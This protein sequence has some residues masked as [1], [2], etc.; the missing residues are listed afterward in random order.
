MDA[1]MMALEPEKKEPVAVAVVAWKTKAVSWS[2]E[3]KHAGREP[4][5]R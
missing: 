4:N 5:D 2:V 1:V 3:L